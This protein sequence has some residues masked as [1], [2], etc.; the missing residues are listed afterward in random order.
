M[1]PTFML[2]SLAS[3]V[4]NCAQPQTADLMCLSHRSPAQKLSGRRQIARVWRADRTRWA[5]ELAVVGTSRH[6]F[7]I[8]S[9]FHL[10][11]GHRRL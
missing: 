1:L 3:S 4:E 2:C 8:V 7:L 9:S 10:G 6:N 11:I 5:L